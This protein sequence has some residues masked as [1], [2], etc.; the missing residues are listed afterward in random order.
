MSFDSLIRKYAP[1]IGCISLILLTHQRQTLMLAW[2][3][4]PFLAI[5]YFIELVKCATGQSNWHEV[6]LRLL[7]W[8][9]SFALIFA[10]HEYRWQ[11]DRKQ[12]NAIAA[13]ITAFNMQQK[14]YPDSLKEIGLHAVRSEPHIGYKLQNGQATLWYLDSKQMYAFHYYHFETRRWDY[15]VP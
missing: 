14:R 10:I 13:K 7:C 1:F 4:L 2:F 11:Q 6:R 3:I 5:A 8:V 15:V 12:L 9:V